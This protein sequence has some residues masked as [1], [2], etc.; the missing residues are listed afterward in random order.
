MAKSNYSMYKLEFLT[1]KW[2]VV[3]K[4]HECLYGLTFDMYTHNN[5]LTYIFMMAKLDT[6]SHEW[7]ASLVNYN[8][9]LY[10]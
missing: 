10:Y 4:I 7:V 3:E 9:W 6:V 2:A 8:F 5:P 1:L